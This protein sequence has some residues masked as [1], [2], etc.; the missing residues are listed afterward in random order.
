MTSWKGPF[1]FHKL[2]FRLLSINVLSPFLSREKVQFGLIS[3]YNLL[4]LS[5]LDFS[6]KYKKDDCV[7]FPPF[8][9]HTKNFNVWK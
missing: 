9:M 4:A 8:G 7:L 6:K 1:W 3:D 2:N 5:D